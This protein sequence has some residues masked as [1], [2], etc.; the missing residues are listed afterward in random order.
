MDCKVGRVTRVL[1]KLKI[2]NFRRFEKLE[3]T[4]LK[5]VNLIAGKN[6]TG[7]TA[8]L[9]AL[10]MLLDLNWSNQLKTAFRN[11][12]NI[13]NERENYWAWLFHNHDITRPITL[14]IETE[15][16]RDYGIAFGFPSAPQAPVPEGFSGW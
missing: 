13:G 6:N 11:G 7:K 1:E 9:E 10:L 2:E 5:R 12:S 4:R 3:F 14:T 16:Y 15:Q 8:V